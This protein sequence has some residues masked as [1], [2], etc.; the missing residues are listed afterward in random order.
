MIAQQAHVT[1]SLS[2]I[3]ARLYFLWCFQDLLP[4][5]SEIILKKWLYGFSRLVRKALM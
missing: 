1:W 3:Y 5:T 4:G 2:L